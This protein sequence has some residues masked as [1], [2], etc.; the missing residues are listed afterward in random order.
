MRNP[1]RMLTLVAT[2]A[3][4]VVGATTLYARDDHGPTDSTTRGGM[5]GGGSMTGQ[6]SQMMDGCGAMMQGG[7]RGRRPND[8]WRKD[9]PNKPEPP[10]KPDKEG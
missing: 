6:M 7:M 2:V 10:T 1:K 4:A 9:T 5:M 8:Q 3:A